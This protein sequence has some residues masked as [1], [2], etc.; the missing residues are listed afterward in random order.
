V[1]DYD[2]LSATENVFVEFSERI[3]M[4]EGRGRR[5]YSWLAGIET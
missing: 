1:A 3:D 5:A 2:H 4:E